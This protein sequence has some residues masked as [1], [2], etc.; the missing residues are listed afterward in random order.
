MFATIL[1]V[2]LWTIEKCLLNRS[3]ICL[4]SDSGNS[5]PR[6]KI[7]DTEKAKNLQ[8]D[9]DGAM[10]LDEMEDLLLGI[11]SDLSLVLSHTTTLS[12]KKYPGNRHWHFKEDVKTKGGLDVTYWPDGSLLWITIRH[13]EPEWVHVTGCEIRELLKRKLGA[14]VC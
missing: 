13:Y 14:Q 2:L 4:A 5:V 3:R 12:K 7:T 9:V 11:A 1:R 6:H 8:V 10:D